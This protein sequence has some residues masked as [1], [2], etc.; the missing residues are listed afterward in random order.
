[1]LTI[2]VCF[3]SEIPLERS[4]R[5]WPLSFLTVLSPSSSAACQLWLTPLTKKGKECVSLAS[6]GQL[7]PCAVLGCVP[8]VSAGSIGSRGMLDTFSTSG[9]KNL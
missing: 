7:S 5:H 9:S 2:F 4:L 1:M 8:T 6:L 3:E